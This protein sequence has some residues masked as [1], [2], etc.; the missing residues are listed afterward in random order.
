MY[1]VIPRKGYGCS[2]E[3]RRR[4]TFCVFKNYVF[5]IAG[6]KKGQVCSVEKTEKGS[7]TFSCLISWD[8][9]VHMGTISSPVFSQSGSKVAIGWKF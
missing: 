4:G 8:D 9:G 6:K 2:K 1:L 3:C 7:G 5:K